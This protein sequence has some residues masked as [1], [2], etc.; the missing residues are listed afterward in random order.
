MQKTMTKEKKVNIY[1][2]HRKRIKRRPGDQLVQILIYV[3]VAAFAITTVAPFLYVIAGSF[4]TERELTERAFFIIPHHFSLNAYRYLLRTGDAF[5][6]LKNSFIVTT[7]GTAIN[8]FFS[9]TLA[10]PLSRSYLKGKN[11]VMNMVI[12]TMLFSGGM[13][14]SYL[15]TVNILHLKDTFWALWLPGAM[16]AFNMVIIKKFYQGLPGELE[17]AAKIDGCND[18]QTFI[19]IMTPLSKPVLASVGLFYAVGHWNAYFNAML[20]IS[21]PKKEVMQIVL[22]RIIF[23][24]SSLS[25]ESGFEWG[26]FGKPPEQAVKMA[27]TVFAIVPILLVY[28]FIQKYF[29]KGVMIGAV[30][31]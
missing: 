20:Y 24:T 15:L 16:G 4:A 2:M 25:S 23:L 31:G 18:L 10:Y 17:D 3:F 22:R 19:K 13:I 8:L 21:D 9:C 6:G 27:T 11:G 7:V 5:K 30:K 26:A 14:P 12:V 1:H 29:T 28:P